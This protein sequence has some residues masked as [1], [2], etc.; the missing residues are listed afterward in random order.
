MFIK[1]IFKRFKQTKTGKQTLNYLNKKLY[2][3]IVTILKQI[4]M[5]K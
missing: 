2:F 5:N 4:L 1:N 3:K